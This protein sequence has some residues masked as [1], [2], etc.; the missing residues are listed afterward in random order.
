[1]DEF[2]TWVERVLPGLVGARAAGPADP[3]GARHHAIVFVMPEDADYAKAKLKAVAVFSSVLRESGAAPGVKIRFTTTPMAYNKDG[4]LDEIEPA[5][6]T[7]PPE[8]H[9]CVR[10]DM[11]W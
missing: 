3:P 1:M 10:V 2:I 7:P 4:I 5:A 6:Q 11:T 8:K 9:R